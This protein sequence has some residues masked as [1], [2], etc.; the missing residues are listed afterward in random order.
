MIIAILFD[1]RAYESTGNYWWATRKLLFSTGIIQSSNR[2]MRLSI[3]DVFVGIHQGYDPEKMYQAA[4]GESG[5]K[6]LHEGRLQHAFYK[7]VI[8]GMV[9]ENMPSTLAEELH[10]VMSPNPGYLGSIAVNFEYGPHLAL[11]RNQLPVQYRLK[12]STCRIFLS[13]GDQEGKDEWEAEALR[14]LG[15]LD[16][17]WEDRGAHNT[18]LDDFDTQEHFRRV[19]IFRTTV[20]SFLENGEDDAYEL[21]LVLE[22]LNPKLFNALGAATERISTAVTEEDVAQAALSGRRFLEQLADVLFPPSKIKRNGRSVDKKDYK[23]RLWAFIEDN[24]GPDPNLRD[25]LG[26]KTD[27]LIEELNGGVHSDRSKQQI[28]EVFADL[29]QFTA[30]L[31]ALNPEASRKPYYAFMDQIKN[32][33]KDIKPITI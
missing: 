2:H 28:L 5:W 1:A 21:V 15:F 22:D 16:V 26:K 30:R 20:A 24:V 8:F 31:L 19:A 11:Y 14:N 7:S 13:M 4:F 12:G 10:A 27:W 23:N 33:L 25:V 17:D 32:F 6:L 9:F 29:A 18:I 3:G